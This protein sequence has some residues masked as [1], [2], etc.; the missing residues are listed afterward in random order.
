MSDLASMPIDSKQAGGEPRVRRCHQRGRESLTLGSDNAGNLTNRS[1]ALAGDLSTNG[2]AF[3]STGRPRRMTN[4][5]VGGITNTLSYDQNGS[6]IQYTAARGVNLFVDCDGDRRVVRVTKGATANDALPTARDEYWCDCKSR[7]QLALTVYYG[8]GVGL[9]FGG[10]AYG[11][12][13]GEAFTFGEVH[14]G[15]SDG[16]IAFG[17]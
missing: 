1:S 6:V 14:P 4:V 12:L 5:N 10:G 17:A 3:T 11:S 13:P 16:Q 2:Q 15:R 7:G 8:R 9:G